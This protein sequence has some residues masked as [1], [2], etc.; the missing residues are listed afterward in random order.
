MSIKLNF[1]WSV[2]LEFLRSFLKWAQKLQSGWLTHIVDQQT[3][4]CVWRNSTVQFV[5]SLVLRV[6]ICWFG[7]ILESTFCTA[8]P[9]R[10]QHGVTLS[11]FVDSDLS[12]NQHSV[13]W[14]HLVDTTL[15]VI[16]QY[17]EDFSRPAKQKDKLKLDK[18]IFWEKTPPKKHQY[19][20][21]KTENFQEEIRGR[22]LIYLDSPFN[23]WSRTRMSPGTPKLLPGS[24]W[25][26]HPAPPHSVHYWLRPI[27]KAWSIWICQLCPSFWGKMS[28]SLFNSL[29][30]A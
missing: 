27:I 29:S 6:T 10:W 23:K 17:T 30:F 19:I 18:V 11:P 8:D 22:V 1:C 20:G 13:R 21:K 16:I 4:W 3:C 5:V 15:F 7:S 28:L 12:S 26:P 9:F 25:E 14:T 24:C 2:P